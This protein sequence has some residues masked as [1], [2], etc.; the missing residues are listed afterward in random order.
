MSAIFR[1]VE[2][3][4]RT[5]SSVGNSA[6]TVKGESDT[7]SEVLGSS[8]STGVATRVAGLD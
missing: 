4:A 8:F 7:F 2:V 6:M 5:L 1:A 3:L